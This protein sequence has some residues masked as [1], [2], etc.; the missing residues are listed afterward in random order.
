MD[1]VTKQGGESY[2][3]STA[4]GRQDDFTEFYFSDFYQQYIPLMTWAEENLDCA[5][6]CTPV[7]YYIFSDVNRGLPENGSQMQR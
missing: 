7:D 3:L 4:A 5:G 6:I 2:C 1:L